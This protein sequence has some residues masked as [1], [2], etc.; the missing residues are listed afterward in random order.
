VYPVHARTTDIFHLLYIKEWQS[1]TA[2]HNRFPA[3]P[4]SFSGCSVR[5]GFPPIPGTR[6]FKGLTRRM[7]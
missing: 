2:L 3:E 7:V 5:R 1:S 6:W 4:F